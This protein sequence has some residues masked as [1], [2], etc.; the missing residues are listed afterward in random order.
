MKEGSTGFCKD[1]ASAAKCHVTPTK[2]AL[3]PLSP[4]TPNSPPS[5]NYPPPSPPSPPLPRVPFLCEKKA[6]PSYADSLQLPHSNQ[7]GGFILEAG[8]LPKRVDHTS[9]CVSTYQ[10]PT[11]SLE[12]H[13]PR[14]TSPRGQSGMINMDRSC[15]DRTHVQQP[16]PLIQHAPVFERC[17]T[18]L[19]SPL[20]NDRIKPFRKRTKRI[21]SKWASR[22]SD[23][24]V[25][26]QLFPEV[27]TIAE[28][29]SDLL[30]TKISPTTKCDTPALPKLPQ[31]SANEIKGS[32]PEDGSEL[33]LDLENQKK[34]FK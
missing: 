34:V 1:T 13:A 6:S 2:N 29:P 15:F 4:P 5:P 16:K 28:T 9:A 20:A 24:K 25:V 18:S 32:I 31:D 7:D 14:H 8:G 22:K 19:A 33:M 17:S 12:A 23:H 26:L 3:P 11:I 10:T 30:P 21:Y 27:P